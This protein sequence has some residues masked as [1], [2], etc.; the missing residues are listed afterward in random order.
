MKREGL[1][2]GLTVLMLSNARLLP[3]SRC[4][5]PKSPFALFVDLKANL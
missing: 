1:V 3:Y 4:A 5:S 2:S